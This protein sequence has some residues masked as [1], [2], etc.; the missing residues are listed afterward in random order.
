MVLL[1]QLGI[2]FSAFIDGG[3]NVHHTVIFT[4]CIKHIFY[5]IALCNHCVKGLYYHIQMQQ[6]CCNSVF[7]SLGFYIFFL[8]L[9]SG[10]F[11]EIHVVYI[12]FW[13]ISMTVAGAKYIVPC[14]S[15]R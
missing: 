1:I 4:F 5:T 15:S 11:S 12:A 10:L 14:I 2:Y 9:F 8:Q 7:I 13:C 6:L 3:A